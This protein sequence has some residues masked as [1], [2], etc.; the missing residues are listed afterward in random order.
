ME[1]AGCPTVPG[2]V[3]KGG[4]GGAIA[5]ILS[6]PGF[7]HLLLS[8][9]YMEGGRVTFSEDKTREIFFA[10]QKILNR[11]RKSKKKVERYKIYLER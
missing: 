4:F 1:N 2:D 9:G 8:T 6:A 10:P 11:Q 5:P 7:L 3:Q